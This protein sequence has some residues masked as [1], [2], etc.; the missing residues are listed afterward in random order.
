M[1]KASVWL[2]LI[3]QFRPD[4]AAAAARAVAHGDSAGI[5][6]RLDPDSFHACPSDSIDYAVMDNLSEEKAAPGAS[7]LVLAPA[8][9]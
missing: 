4:I 7:A 2:S 5:F 3:H 8:V 6:L 9:G 1:L